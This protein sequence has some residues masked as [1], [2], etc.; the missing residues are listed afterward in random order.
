M[1]E[2]TVV[3]FQRFGFSFS[4]IPLLYLRNKLSHAISNERKG[5]RA[6]DDYMRLLYG[7][8]AARGDHSDSGLLREGLTGR[9]DPFLER[10]T[11]VL[12]T[13]SGKRKAISEFKKH[14]APLG[15]IH[16]LGDN[17]NTDLVNDVPF[18]T[19]LSL[20]GFFLIA[21]LWDKFSERSSSTADLAFMFPMCLL[22]SLALFRLS[23][24]LPRGYIRMRINFVI[25][26]LCSVYLALSSLFYAAVKKSEELT[27]R[28]HDIASALFM[29]PLCIIIIG[30]AYSVALRR[31]IFCRKEVTGYV[32][33]VTKSSRKSR[34]ATT[35][36]TISVIATYRFEGVEYTRTVLPFLWAMNKTTD[37]GPGSVITV[38]IDPREPGCSRI[39]GS[40]PILGFILL[41]VG[42]LLF[43]GLFMR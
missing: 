28:Y 17:A 38:C 12:E 22:I 4:K 30:L 27:L 7:Y 18:V 37:L 40:I 24:R 5:R 25:A 21:I 20:A 33:G 43:F 19:F 6:D 1:D 16:G 13:G 26:G 36:D 14:F 34:S 29:Y 3:M 32:T 35:P 10:C 15:R 23:G 41:L 8:M 42:I 2:R 31:L 39:K 9:D 11:E